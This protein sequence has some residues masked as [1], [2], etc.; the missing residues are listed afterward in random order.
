MTSKVEKSDVD[1]GVG[2]LHSHCGPTF[3]DDKFFCMH[4]I[5]QAGRMGLCDR[6]AGKIDPVDWC[7]LYKR[8]TAR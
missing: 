4:F 1:Y 7:N 5:P 2:H 3:H 6:V 8:T